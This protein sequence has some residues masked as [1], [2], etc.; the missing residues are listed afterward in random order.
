MALSEDAIRR[1]VEHPW[2]GNV[3]ELRNDQERVATL[4]RSPVIARMELRCEICKK[5]H[6]FVLI[7]CT[8][9]DRA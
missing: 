7:E 1:L 2:P 6:E 5:R 4:V 8:I 3:R 9:D